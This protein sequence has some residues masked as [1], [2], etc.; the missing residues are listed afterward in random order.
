MRGS[1]AAKVPTARIGVIQAAVIVGF[2]LLA[3]AFW[4]FQII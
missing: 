3:G 2:V 1:E 4:F